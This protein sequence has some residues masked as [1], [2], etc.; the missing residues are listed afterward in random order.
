MLA[1]SAMN[2]TLASTAHNFFGSHHFRHLYDTMVATP[3]RPMEVALGELTFSVISG[4]IYASSFVTLMVVMDLTT[5][6]RAL[7]A[8]L[9]SLLIGVAFAG[10]AIII[11]TYMRG[12]PD[13][14]LVYLG[15]F[16][17]FMLSGTFVPPE[18]YPVAVQWLMHASPLYQSITLL[19]AITLGTPDPTDWLVALAYLV[20]FGLAGIT[21]AAR[22]VTHMLYR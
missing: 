18:H 6:P 19:R 4:A 7:L 20:V 17:L 3:V 1:A 10:A 12:W 21:I 8:L 11:A 5:W 13:I 16:V 2:A 14:S 9:A 15:Q 22:R